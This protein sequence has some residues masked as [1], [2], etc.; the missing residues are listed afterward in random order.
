DVLLHRALEHQALG[1]PVLGQEAQAAADR[2]ARSAAAHGLALD[3]HAPLRGRIRPRDR[4]RQLGAAS[5]QEA[6]QAHDLA[7]AQREAD[8]LERPS[9]EALDA[10]QLLARGRAAARVV[11]LQLAVRHEADELAQA[12]RAYDAGG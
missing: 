11:L 6:G 7:A 9:R 10:Q 12:D 4:P 8:V 5:P 2:V 1:L 3:R